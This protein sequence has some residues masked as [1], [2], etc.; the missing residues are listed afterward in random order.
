MTHMKLL[1][2]NY[3]GVLCAQVRLG[4]LILSEDRYGRHTCLP[5]HSH[6]NS[7]LILSLNG[8]QVE[9]LNGSQR[10]YQRHVLAL[11]PAGETHSQH[12]GAEGFRCL[13]LEFGTQWRHEQ[14]EVWG[15]FH[16]P[17]YLD[18]SRFPAAMHI[19]RN[20]YREFRNR[21]DFSP[22]AIEGGI[23]C[24]L[25]EIGGLCSE[26]QPRIPRWL[27]KVREILHAHAA[28]HLAVSTL[29]A[30]L[31]VHPVHLARAFSRHYRY[32]MGEYVRRLRINNAC[33]QIRRGNVRL[34]D[35]AL[36]NG[37]ADQAHFTR[38]FKRCTGMTPRQFKIQNNIH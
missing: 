8:S 22:L 25:A 28:E 27:T 10:S 30:S 6:E 20:I 17:M 7:H 36:N 29:A 1:V 35:V 5:K 24:F 31:G 14:S 21:D 12:I 13:H 26:P 18:I 4:D 23:L 2:G 33:E 37:F 15:P 3:F 9:H 16:Q 32:T 38:V 34:V 11:H 19:A